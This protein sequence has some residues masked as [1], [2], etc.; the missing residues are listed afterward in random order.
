MKLWQVW[1]TLFPTC[2]TASQAETR[3]RRTCRPQEPGKA[4]VTRY[5]YGWWVRFADY[6]RP[7]FVHRGSGVV[8]YPT[9][10]T[11]S[12]KTTESYFADFHSTR[13][14]WCLC[15]PHSYS[16]S[17]ALES[18]LRILCGGSYKYFPNTSRH[19]FLWW[20]VNLPGL[21]YRYENAFY[22]PWVRGSEAA[23]EWLAKELE[24]Q[25]ISSQRKLL[26]RRAARPTRL[27]RLS[28]FQ[29]PLED[30]LQDNGHMWHGIAPECLFEEAN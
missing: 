28:H 10:L 29:M 16:E 8:Y 22:G 15:F 9:T 11:P 19:K 26:S 6:D 7:C 21:P 24:A 25:G 17:L 3:A 5:K 2:L 27:F 20:E 13:R 23:I 12:Q 18:T 14:V 30:A 4:T 1:D